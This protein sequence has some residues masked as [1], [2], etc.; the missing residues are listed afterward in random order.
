MTMFEALIDEGWRC[1]RSELHV[2]EQDSMKEPVN[3]RG[4]KQIVETYHELQIEGYTVSIS[5]IIRT[6]SS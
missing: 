3:P 5:L 6:Q 2:H 4:G 1:G